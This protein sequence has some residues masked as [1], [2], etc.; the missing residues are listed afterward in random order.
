[1]GAKRQ[2]EENRINSTQG[3]ENIGEIGL[4]E[5]DHEEEQGKTE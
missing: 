5:K 3:T 2:R 4:R 1:M